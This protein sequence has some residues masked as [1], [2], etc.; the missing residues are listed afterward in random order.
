M[1]GNLDCCADILHDKHLAKKPRSDLM[2]RPKQAFGQ[3]RRGAT[4]Q[5]INVNFLFGISNGSLNVTSLALIVVKNWKGKLQIQSR[6]GLTNGCS[7]KRRHWRQRLCLFRTGSWC[8]D[9]YFYFQSWN[10]SFLGERRCKVPLIH[11][12]L[13]KNPPRSGSGRSAKCSL[14]LWQRMGE[15]AK[16]PRRATVVKK[17]H[18]KKKWTRWSV[19]VVSM[20]MCDNGLW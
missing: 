6:T 12:F 11:F 17:R 18:S 20:S 5:I 10:K 14:R 7:T 16:L 4:E 9:S 8:H 1:G 13:L 3:L 2:T 15:D 19:S